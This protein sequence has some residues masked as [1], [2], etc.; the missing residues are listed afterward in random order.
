MPV[1]QYG[2]QMS[3][4][5]PPR[6]TGA[7]PARPVSKTNP[8]PPP[9]GPA[10]GTNVGPPPS[11]MAAPPPGFNTGLWVPPP[12]SAPGPPSNLALP[13]GAI[14]PT[15]GVPARPA[16]QPQGSQMASPTAGF[17]PPPAGVPP[18]PPMGVGGAP[19]WMGAFMQLLGQLNLPP[20]VMQHLSGIFGGPTGPPPPSPGGVQPGMDYGQDYTL[21]P[22]PA[23]PGS[24]L[25]PGVA[26]PPPSPM[27][28]P[29]TKPGGP[30]T[31]ETTGNFPMRAP[32]S[33]PPNTRPA[34][35]APQGGQGIGGQPAVTAPGL[36]PWQQPQAGQVPFQR[37]A[38]A[39]PPTQAPQGRQPWQAMQGM[40]PRAEQQPWAARL[41]NPSGAT[42]PP[43][44]AP[45]PGLMPGYTGSPAAIKPQTP[46][47][48]DVGMVGGPM[49]APGTPGGFNR[50]NLRPP[51]PEDMDPSVPNYG[52]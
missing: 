15:P 3:R 14:P 17:M 46:P 41:T 40:I 51:G 50:A 45:K 25:P 19:P 22:A 21:T 36:Q 34:V 31:T 6:P 27:E 38:P 2:R 32:A 11:P 13:P 8:A 47:P 26:L 7:G 44:S 33:A 28:T 39:M 23:P 10:Y 30:D 5:Q 43:T 18:V 24:A 49:P 20:Q 52:A 1:P 9:P 29:G 42:N 37:P 35:A 16:P 12:T 4:P 48:P